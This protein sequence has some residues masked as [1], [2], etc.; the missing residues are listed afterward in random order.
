MVTALGLMVRRSI[1]RPL[2]EVSEGAR[3]LSSG[4]LSFGVRYRG[5]DEIGNVA[6]SLGDLRLSAERMAREIR[7]MNTAIRESRL[8]HRAE[9]G[10]FEGTW[11]QLLAGM[12]G[13]I[14]AFAALHSQE[15]ALRRVATLVAR[16]APPTEIFDAVVAETRELLGADA[17]RLLC[18]EPDGTAKVV[19][20]SDPGLEIPVGTRL[21]LEG[22]NVAALVRRT[23]LPVRLEGFEGT[24]G[25]IAALL[26]EQGIHWAVG[27]PVLVEGHVWG[28][29]AA[30]WR[31]QPPGSSDTEGHMAQFTELLATAIANAHSREQLSASRARLVAASDA[32][33]R[34][35][36]RD[37]HDGVQQRLVSLGL[38]LRNVEAMLPRGLPELQS[39]LERV[40]TGLNDA[41]EEL[42]A[43]SRGIHPTILSVGGLGPAL[44]TLTR[45]SPVPVELDVEEGI[46]LPERLEVAV[47]YVVSEAL[48]NAAKHAHASVVHIELKTDGA[49]AQLAIRDDG[50]G[51][52]DPHRGSGLTGLVD[53][54]EAAGGSIR[55][56]S[57]PT[58]GTSLLV[59]LPIA[60]E[61]RVRRGRLS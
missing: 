17:A 12:N 33:R 47:Y 41:Y 48:A 38:E 6:D 58:R 16:G 4:D 34:R 55:I 8:E 20:A 3:K 57:P 35:I 26:R 14:E 30:A 40:V 13:T 18:Y 42:R 28:M 51:G 61:L 32:T 46:S 54:V 24:P 56:T 43:I 50:T 5:S 59:A 52:A 22:N 49:T 11:S 23:G 10:A 15:A 9:P 53:R 27:A 29:M 37:L 19:A 44:R 36:E 7:L 2:L 60:G 25:S 1:T 39:Q 45:R 31:Q 21:S